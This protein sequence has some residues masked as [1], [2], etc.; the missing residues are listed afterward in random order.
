IHKTRRQGAFSD[1]EKR[2][3]AL[4]I[5]HLARS[6]QIADRMTAGLNGAAL[7]QAILHSLAVG[8]VLVDRECRIVQANAVA[9]RLLRNLRWFSVRQGNVQPVHPGD[10]DEFARRVAAAAGAGDGLG[11]GGPMRLRDPVERELALLVAPFRIPL[12]GRQEAR[13]AAIVFSDPDAR[14][15]PARSD[16]ARVLGLSP[17]EAELVSMLAE[18]ATLVEAARGIG[19][20]INTAKTQLKSVFQ[21]T[22]ARRQADVIEWIKREPVLQ[23]WAK[24]KE[25]DP[26]GEGR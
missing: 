15:T 3:Y 20:S 9:E 25:R 14:S 7:D 6:L 2:R 18:G 24:W 4:L 13:L 23:L 8:V 1:P 17:A 26:D 11:T 12:K 21:K 10:R 5:R 19:I 22:G 16:I